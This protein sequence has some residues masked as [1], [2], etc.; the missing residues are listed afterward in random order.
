MCKLLLLGS[1]AGFVILAGKQGAIAAGSTAAA[2]PRVKE[3]VLGYTP[4]KN[5]LGPLWNSLVD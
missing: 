1:T 3:Q 2:N 5:S 4:W